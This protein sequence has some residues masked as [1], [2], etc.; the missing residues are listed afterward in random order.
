MHYHLE[1]WLEEKP[2]PETLRGQIESILAPF[3]EELQLVEYKENVCQYPVADNGMLQAMIQYR[4]PRTKKKRIQRKWAKRPENWRPLEE[5]S[6]V[7]GDDRYMWNPIG[8]FDWFQIGG[9]WR[10]RHDPTYDP[11]EDYSLYELCDICRGT[12][13]RRDALGVVTRDEDPSYTCNG[14]GKYNNE[15]KRW[16]HDDHGPGLR[17]SWPTQWGMHPIDVIALQDLPEDFTCYRLIV[18]REGKVVQMF[19]KEH[20]YHDGK[21]FRLKDTDFDGNVQKQL[22]KLNIR[23]G[24]LVT[25]DYH[26]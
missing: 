5:I 4:F 24:Y 10:G 1:V 9:R 15:T 26:A 18:V 16:E 12:G 19:Y 3:S 23:D 21:R 2:Q 11:H 8:F 20:F 14:C 6:V 7:V 13:F 17:M 22:R 25:V